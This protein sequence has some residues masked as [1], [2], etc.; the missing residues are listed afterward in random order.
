M[1]SQTLNPRA[2]NRFEAATKT[3]GTQVSSIV[4]GLVSNPSLSN[5]EKQLKSS[6]KQFATSFEQALAPINCS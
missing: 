2:S 4:T 5:A 6:L 1:H 3:L